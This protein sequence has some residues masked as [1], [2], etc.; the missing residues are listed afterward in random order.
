MVVG[1]LA[2]S[3]LIPVVGGDAPD[4]PIRAAPLPVYGAGVHRVGD[5]ASAMS[6]GRYVTAGPD[7]DATCRVARLSGFGGSAEDVVAERDVEGPTTL[8]VIRA[9]A[10]VVLEGPCTWR[11]G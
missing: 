10:G 9:D 6:A 2:V 8:R 7:D 4:G 3:G 1:V 11:M 5:A